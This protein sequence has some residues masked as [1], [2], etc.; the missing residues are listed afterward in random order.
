MRACLAQRKYNCRLTFTHCHSHY[1]HLHT[2]Q[3]FL[4]NVR[5]QRAAGYA[6]VELAQALREVV[7]ARRAG[8]QV[9]VRSE[10]SSGQA[11]SA[12]RHLFGW[13]DAMDIVVKWRQLS[14]PN[15]QV[16]VWQGS[17]GDWRGL[18]GTGGSW[19]GLRG[20][21]SGVRARAGAEVLGWR[22]FAGAMLC[23]SCPEL[24]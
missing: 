6:A 17:G 13:R 16:R 9:W 7:A 23:A 21:G 11:G 22:V 20:P 4:P 18:V 2:P 14:E 8:R 3:G 19:R 12:G 10:G 15:D 24:H 1:A 5:Q